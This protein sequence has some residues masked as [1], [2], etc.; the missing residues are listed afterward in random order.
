ML[1]SG[2]FSLELMVWFLWISPFCGSCLA[3][4]GKAAFGLIFGP[5]LVLLTA[6]SVGGV[7]RREWEDRSSAPHHREIGGW[8]VEAKQDRGSRDGRSSNYEKDPIEC[9]ACADLTMRLSTLGDWYSEI[10]LSDRSGLE[11]ESTNGCGRQPDPTLGDGR[12]P[13]AG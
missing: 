1:Y 11:L 5:L 10:A 3:A 12:P 8:C 4:G 13:L 6:S 2:F 7:E 9:K